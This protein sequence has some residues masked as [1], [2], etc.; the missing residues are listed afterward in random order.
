M[1]EVAETFNFYNF[2][3]YVSMLGERSERSEC[4]K[5]K[6]RQVQVELQQSRAPEE[7]RVRQGARFGPDDD[8]QVT[9]TIDD[10]VL[11][12]SD[13]SISGADDGS[14]WEV[15]AVVEADQRRV[16]IVKYIILWEGQEGR[17]STKSVSPVAMTGLGGWLGV[18]FSSLQTPFSDL[19]NE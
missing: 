18:C 4:G 10:H 14:G 16:S 2:Y 13:R 12:H 8:V 17:G 1:D 5:S 9:Q 6:W 19:A 15:V 11:L 3:N 7:V